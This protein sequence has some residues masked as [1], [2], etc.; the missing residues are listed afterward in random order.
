MKSTKCKL[1]GKTRKIGDKNLPIRRL[2]WAPLFLKYESGY[3]N[4][5]IIKRIRAA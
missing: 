5:L 1:T 4:W 3:K 2:S